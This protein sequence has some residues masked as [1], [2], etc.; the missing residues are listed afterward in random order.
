M[1]PPRWRK[2]V[3]IGLLTAMLIVHNAQRMGVV[4]VFAELLE[5]FGTDYSGI[6]TLFG[7][8]VLGYALA[9]VAVGC[10]GD[11][12]NARQ[13]LLTGLALS[14]I[15]SLLFAWTAS[16]PLALGSRFLLGTTGALLYTPAMKLGITLFPSGERG[17]IL[18]TLQAGAGF[19]I[20][21]A[22]IAIPLAIR[23]FGMTGGFATLP[24]FTAAV[25]LAG[26]RQN[27][28]DDRDHGVL[29]VA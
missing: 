12:Y 24:L 16:Y 19:G 22:L 13:L 4:P 23:Q 18:G 21:G 1:T 28:G 9:Q 25:L 15:L 7:A 11:R 3:T 10:F 6:G 27:W 29:R 26:M 14:A 20:V 17:R 8:Y 2:A 5:R